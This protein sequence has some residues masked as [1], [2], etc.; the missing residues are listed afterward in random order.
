MEEVIS[1]KTLG[2]PDYTLDVYA[3]VFDQKLGKYQTPKQGRGSYLY[4]T[5]RNS[6]T[7]KIDYWWLHRLVA[8]AYLPNPEGREQVDHINGNK[9][10][11]RVMNLRWASNRENAHAAIRQNLMPH[12]VFPNDSVVHS[13]CQRL[14]N[15]DTVQ[16]ISDD[17]GYPYDSIYAIRCGRNWTHVSSQYSF[18]DTRIRQVLTDWQV[19]EICQAI[20]DGYDDVQ[21]ADSIGTKSGNVRN[22]RIKKNFKEISDQYF[23]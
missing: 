8:T 19:H 2:Y 7:G 1:L 20:V 12:A 6:V 9:C 10:D 11:N 14:A 13:I 18:P 23:T 4:V 16:S 3:N 5:L 17:T 22:I 15:G 21:I